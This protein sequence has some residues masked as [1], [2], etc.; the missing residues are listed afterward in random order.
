MPQEEIPS[1]FWEQRKTCQNGH[2]R[3]KGWKARHIYGNL[4]KWIISDHN[5]WK[6]PFTHEDTNF[7]GERGKL[8]YHLEF[9]CTKFQK[10]GKDFPAFDPACYGERR[11]SIAVALVS[12]DSNQVSWQTSLDQSGWGEKK[13][14]SNLLISLTAYANAKTNI[15]GGSNGSYRYSCQPLK[16]YSTCDRYVR[17]CNPETPQACYMLSIIL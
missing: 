10:S 11:I 1:R 15:T 12:A 13:T 2:C 7:F 9:A 16:K 6:F 14:T 8:N 5:A 3:L 4:W 17:Q